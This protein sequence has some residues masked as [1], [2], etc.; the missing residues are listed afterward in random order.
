MPKTPEQ[1]RRMNRTVLEMVRSM[2]A[3]AKLS[4]EFWAEL[5]HIYEI[6][7]LLGLLKEERA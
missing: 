1:N 7:V 5:Q 4:Q 3:D 6:E 2:L